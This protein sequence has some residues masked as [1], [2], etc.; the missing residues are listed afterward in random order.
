MRLQGALQACSKSH[1]ENSE[2]SMKF[3]Q[4]VTSEIGESN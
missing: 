1:V 3:A 2:T 4:N